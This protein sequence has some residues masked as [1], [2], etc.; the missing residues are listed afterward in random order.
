MLFLIPVAVIGYQMYEKKQKEKEAAAALEEGR[1]DD[2][3][4][5]KV[6]GDDGS[7]SDGESAIEGDCE[8]P[9]TFDEKQQCPMPAHGNS[10]SKHHGDLKSSKKEQPE[11]LKRVCKSFQNQSN[12]FVIRSAR[13]AL[14]Y[15]VMGNQGSN[16]LPFPKIATH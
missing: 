14:T 16:A 4:Q 1:Q 9:S 6:V 12:P 8:R 5:Q 11:W 15:E 7:E 10:N 2:D 3:V 13:E